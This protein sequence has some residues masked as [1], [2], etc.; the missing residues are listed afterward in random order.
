[1]INAA[2]ITMAVAASLPKT[3]GH[4]FASTGTW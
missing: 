3:S 1:V 4:N 2:I